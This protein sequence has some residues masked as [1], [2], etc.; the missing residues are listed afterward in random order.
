MA[1]WPGT[2]LYFKA[3]VKKVLKDENSADLLFED[4]TEMDIPFEYISVS[5]IHSV[6]VITNDGSAN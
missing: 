4:G 2:Q 3:T 5:A 6:P 1:K